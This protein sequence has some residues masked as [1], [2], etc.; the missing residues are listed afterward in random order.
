[1]KGDA[2]FLVE[3]GLLLALLGAAGAI[4]IKIGLS[5]VPLFLVAGL[6]IAEGSPV[7]VD[8]A[9]PFLDAAAAVGV[10]LLMLALGLEFSTSE[11]TSAITK[12]AGSGVLDFALN[13]TPGFLMGLA[14]RWPWPACLALAGVTWVSSSGIVAK[15]LSDLN[16]LG[17]RETPAVLSV[18]VI[19]DVA[20]AIY[21]P[22]L[23]VVLV[24][25]ELIAGSVRAAIALAVV[26]VLLILA[27]RFEKVVERLLLHDD[28]E[29]V[30][31]RV[32]GLTLLV[33]GL[34]E[35]MG[36]SAA[37]GAFLV[38]VAIPAEAARRARAV[39]EPLRDLFAAVFFLA[40]A[41]LLDV[42]Q[43]PAVLPVAVLLAAVT[44]VTKVMTGWYAARRE[45]V[46]ARGRMRAGTVLVAR[47]EFSM[48]IA[49]LAVVAGYEEL[50]T[51]ATAYVL[52]LAVTGPILTR[53]ADTLASPWVRRDAARAASP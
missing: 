45:G 28:S 50:G 11:F 14:L 15:L 33:A 39:L 34:S 41:S 3:L 51:L 16:R 21:L 24:G 48:V 4:A 13:A 37:V 49:G 20:M 25:G 22:I 36:I 8:S 30:M 9:R 2:A 29:Q 7:Q 47:G 31:L 43:V 42:Q 38:G 18:L 5:T 12:Q 44:L 40:F 6:L 10:V 32:L 35:V 23:G 52:V 26:V 17:N 46:G 19:E 1:M 53:F 27:R